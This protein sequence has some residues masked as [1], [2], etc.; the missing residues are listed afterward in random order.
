MAVRPKSICRHAACGKS[1]AAPGYC[2]KHTKDKIGWYATSGKSSTERGYG[3]KW[4]K[5]RDRIMARDRW[6]CQV[7]WAN[8]RVTDA[9]AVDHIKSKGAGGT[10]DPLNLRAICHKCHVDKTALDRRK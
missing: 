6:L 7:C 3:W 8:N 10:D 9:T 4:K 1:I 2:E 5:L